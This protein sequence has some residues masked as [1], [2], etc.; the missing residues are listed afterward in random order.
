VRPADRPRRVGGRAGSVG[1]MSA[2]VRDMTADDPA[3]IAAAMA[4]LGWDKPL[5]QYEDYLAQHVA[6]TRHVFV[7]DTDGGAFA[8]YVTLRWA[9]DYEPFA[10]DG[11]PE[12]SD[13][14]VLPSLRRAG[15]GNALLDAAEALAAT[16]SDVVGL[17]VGLLADYGAAQRVYVRRGYQ[18]DG[19]GI[20]YRDRPVGYA[21]RIPIDDDATLML[22]KSVR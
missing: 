16:R 13:L 7:A 20:M 21:E 5:V 3:R 22:T 19:R 4:E 8:G 12:V 11:V 10:A 1:R 17:G 15:I 9:S 2:T 18:F 6:G 14:N